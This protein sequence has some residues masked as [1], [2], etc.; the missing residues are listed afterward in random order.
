M[1]K[2]KKYEQ[3]K[4]FIPTPEEDRAVLN[5]LLKLLG[6]DIEVKSYYHPDIKGRGQR[7]DL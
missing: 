6:K 1:S 2:K 7:E 5:E 3:P 4:P